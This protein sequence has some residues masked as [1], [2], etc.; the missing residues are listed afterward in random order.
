MYFR[1][2]R[3]KSFLAIQFYR[4][5]KLK[6]LFQFLYQRSKSTSQIKFQWR[7]SFTWDDKNRSGGEWI[8]L[9]EIK[10]HHFLCFLCRYKGFL[11]FT[12]TSQYLPLLMQSL[13]TFPSL[14]YDAIW[15]PAIK[16]WNALFVTKIIKIYVHSHV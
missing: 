11:S 6:Y 10:L 5:I 13:R 1:K 9:V 12:Y 14:C 4:K 2:V 7:G 16:L 8:F 3:I 15:Q